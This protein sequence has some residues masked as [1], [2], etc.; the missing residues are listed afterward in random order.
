MRSVCAQERG[1]PRGLL[2]VKGGRG[3][4]VRLGAI[5]GCWVLLLRLH[6]RIS[7]DVGVH[8]ATAGCGAVAMC[9]SITLVPSCCCCGDCW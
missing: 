2:C 8:P 5:W 9:L 1:I 6:C 3:M 4:C 7:I